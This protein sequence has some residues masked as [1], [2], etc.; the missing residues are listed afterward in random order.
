MQVIVELVMPILAIFGL[1]KFLNNYEQKEEK[2]KALKYTVGITAGLAIGFY[3]LKGTL[4][5][6]V[7]NRDG[8]LRESYGPDFLKLIKE[9]RESIFTIDVLRT[10]IFVLLSATVLWMYLKE[11]VKE[12]DNLF[13]L[14]RYL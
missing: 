3:L 14:P 1:H 2:L 10:L 8:V 5:D 6:F 9:Q 4:F 13:V 12:N 7:G 11:K